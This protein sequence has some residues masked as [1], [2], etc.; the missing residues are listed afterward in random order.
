M[1]MKKRI[2][3]MS[4]A[5]ALLTAGCTDSRLA[6][7]GTLE[8]QEAEA[9]PENVTE[10]LE[11]ATKVSMH[12]VMYD[13]VNS[14]SVWGLDQAEQTPTEGF[15]MMVIKGSKK[16]TLPTIRNTREPLAH[17]NEQT[18]DLWITS[19]EMEG[20]GVQVERLYKVR[21]HDDSTAYIA[22]QIA[23]YDVQQALIPRLSYST[24]EQLLT[25]YADGQPLTTVKDRMT[26]SMGGFDNE[27]AVW[28]GEQL[29]FDIGGDSPKVLV[30]PGVKY[31]TGLVL[32]YE[33][34]PTLT[35]TLTLADDGTVS[36]GDIKKLYLPY[37]GSYADVENGE[38]CLDIT[39]R[40]QDGKY[41]VEMSLFRMTTFLDDGIGIASDFGLTYTA[42]DGEGQPI[43]GRITL[44]GDT[45]TV[46]FTDSQWKRIRNGQRVSFVKQ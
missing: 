24:N 40:R 21:F 29:T 9:V 11:K 10:A 7:R 14:I 41:D 36:A 13:S 5:V 22:A 2:L 34:M 35:A 26:D 6:V 27:S 45:L 8:G 19:S 43:S 28:I 12:S 20:T 46:T 44:Q 3:M 23:P 1:N 4:C 39:Y 38:P 31:T 18:G 15:G 16:T 25:L 33:Q 30:V 17:Y 32:N 42:T 37:V